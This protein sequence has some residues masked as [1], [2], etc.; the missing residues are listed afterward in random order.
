MN[1]LSDETKVRPHPCSTA[2]KKSQ[3]NAIGGI[4]NGGALKGGRRKERPFARERE[5]GRF[6]SLALSNVLF[7]H[8]RECCQTD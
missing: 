5:I 4:N 2:E 1:S 8:D 7:S 3:K 6:R